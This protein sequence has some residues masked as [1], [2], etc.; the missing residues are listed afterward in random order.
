MSNPVRA[1]R[2]A[3]CALI[4]AAVAALVP[5]HAQEAAASREEWGVY[6]DLVGH[7]FGTSSSTSAAYRIEWAVPGEEIREVQLTGDREGTVTLIRRAGPG[8]LSASVRKPLGVVQVWDGAIQPDGSIHFVRDALIKMPYGIAMGPQGEF[9][10]QS[11][12]EVD[13]RWTVNERYVNRYARQGAP[14]RDTQAVAS[15][16]LE[17]RMAEPAPAVSKAEV[18]KQARSEAAGAAKLAP[19]TPIPAATA[20]AAPPAPA[21]TPVPVPVPA[22]APVA[23][24]IPPASALPVVAEP[25]ALLAG[26]DQWLD[27]WRFVQ[28][29]KAVEFRLRRLRAEG[30][31][32]WFRIQYRVNYSDPIYTP[33]SNGYHLYRATARDVRYRVDFPPSFTGV[34]RIYELPIEIGLFADGEHVEWDEAT[35]TLVYHDRVYEARGSSSCVDDNSA[36]SRCDGYYR[37]RDHVIA[38]EYRFVAE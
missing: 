37:W 38:P 32:S 26:S 22:P 24:A 15:V 33:L 12:R 11:L 29:D 5:L 14:A 25:A 17:T 27:S 16:E 36:E 13:G 20:A 28:G 1:A 23:A 18:L 34:D 8:R 9:L 30:T 21:P 6:A 19:P 35:R 31:T 7:R 10:T 3:V 4:L 2:A